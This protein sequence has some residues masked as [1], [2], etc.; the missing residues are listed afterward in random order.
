MMNGT[1]R[2]HFRPLQIEDAQRILDIYS[3]KEAMKYRASGPILNHTQAIDM[4]RRAMVERTRGLVHRI[5]VVQSSS[6]TLMGTVLIKHAPTNTESFIGYS[7]DQQFWN[8]GYGTEVVGA[9][10]QHLKSKACPL[11]KARVH[12]QNIGSIKILEKQGFHQV[13]QTE[14]PDLYLYQLC[15]EG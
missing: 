13:H 15:P 1:E 6:N 8:K 7:L 9:I 4:I 12:P 3:D 11:I 14:F 5:A 2:L 10:V